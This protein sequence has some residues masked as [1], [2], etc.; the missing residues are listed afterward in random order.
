MRPYSN[1][2]RERIVAAVDRGEHSLRQLADLFAVSL[3]CIV[4]LLQRRR[5]SG[6]VVPKPHGGGT[7]PKIDAPALERLRELL[8]AQPDATLAELR[9]RL[10]LPCSIM[11]IDRAL[12]RAG[13]TRK[14]KT[15]R[16]DR[17]DDPDVQ[18]QRDTFMQRL[19]QVDPEHLVFVDEMGANTA[20]TRT[21]G[22]SPAGTR[23][24][25]SAPGAWKNVTLIAAVRPSEVGA[26]LAFE[27]ATD[28]QAFRTYVHEVLVPQVEAGDVVVWDNLNVH[29]DAEVIA[30][31]EAVG[32]RVEPLP[33]YSPDLSPIEEMFSK[34]KELL[35]TLGAR[36]VTA[37]MDAL[38]IALR[39]ITPSD[40]QGWFQDRA[41]Y[42][43]QT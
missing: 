1:D 3:S 7:Q 32:A 11:A 31:L 20:M 36:T 29:Q 28:Q 9:D 14:Q 21:H 19:S 4:R 5:D 16:A 24:Y 41:A 43:N 33:P 39:L 15:L 10:G 18:A 26:T 22:R 40:I 25:A 23:V 13:I 2:L 37:V 30:A 34:I 35:R 8:R 38:G 17:Q 12:R 27:G 6:S 42:A